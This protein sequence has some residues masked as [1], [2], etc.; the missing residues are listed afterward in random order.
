[1]YDHIRFH[2]DEDYPAG[3][4]PERAA[5]H[6]GMYWRWTASQ[7]LHNPVWQNT[8]ETAADFAAMQSGTISGADFL[9]KHMDGALTPDDFNESGRRFTEFYYDDEEDGY[10]SFMEDYI[11]TL[12]TPSLGGLYHVADNA[13]N[14]AKLAPVF[15]MAFTRWQNSLKPD[16][17]HLQP[18]TTQIP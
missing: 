7:G 17:P 3:L 16:S 15:Q 6:I 4:P 12:D 10:G 13:E 14:Y 9:L 18:Q 5:T 11:R 1:M 8:P 2:T